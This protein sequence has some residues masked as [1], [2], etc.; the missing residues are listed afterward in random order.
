LSSIAQ[1]R[2]AKAFFVDQV[3][4]QV[5]V[6]ILRFLVAGHRHDMDILSHRTGRLNNLQ[7]IKQIQQG[8]QGKTADRLNEILKGLVL[9]RGRLECLSFSI[10]LQGLSAFLSSGLFLDSP[11]RLDLDKGRLI[12]QTVY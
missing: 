2:R 12:F 10:P 1:V 6:C 5:T 7:M 9:L 4:E 8:H 3:L 11:Y